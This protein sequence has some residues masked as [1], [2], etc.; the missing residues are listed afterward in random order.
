M[1]EV[2]ERNWQQELI[3]LGLE[4]GRGLGLEEGRGLG[5][6]EGALR[7]AR[8]MVLRLLGNR[9][10]AVSEEVRRRVESESDVSRLDAAADAVLGPADLDTVL[11]V[12][13]QA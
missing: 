5:L 9:F 11:S 2:I 4:R 13:S 12:L 8:G 10:G 1:A 7:H 3:D 6:E